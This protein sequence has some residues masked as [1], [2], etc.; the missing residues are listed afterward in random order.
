MTER[1]HDP[2]VEGFLAVSAAR[3]GAAHG[4]RV[5]PRPDRRRGRARKA[6]RR[7]DARGSRALPRGAPR[8]GA[9]PRRRSRGEPPRSARSSATRRCSA[10]GP[11]T[12]PPSSTCRAARAGCRGRSRRARPSGWSRPPSG[13]TPRALRD[14]ALVELLYGAGLRV[15]EAVGLEKG[16][17]D[18]EERLVRTVGKGGKE[19]VVPIGREAAEALRRYLAHGR[20][21]PRPPAPAR[22]LPQRAGRRAH[23]RRRVPDPAPARG[24][25]RPR[26]RA[27][28]P[29]PAAALVRDAPARGRR[30]PAQRAGDARPRRPRHD[31]AL[32]PRHRPPPPRGL[33]PGA[34]PCQADGLDVWSA[35]ADA[36]NEAE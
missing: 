1:T 21:A 8:A 32:H 12:R 6:G 9:A 34:P 10:R 26:A 27:R 5:P 16:G 17:V 35:A 33:L 36:R 28:P 15:S 24:Q 23:A 30:R 20:A 3:L 19:R 14:H 25:G 4:R 29:A 22:A 13:T 2:E 7:G 18:L 31:R 11:T